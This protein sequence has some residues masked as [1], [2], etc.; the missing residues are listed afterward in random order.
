MGTSGPLSAG[1]SSWC[2]LASAEQELTWEPL[3]T[4]CY[5]ARG[6]C[7]LPIPELL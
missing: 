5:E 7:L 3:S 1:Q 2:Y 4:R 6:P